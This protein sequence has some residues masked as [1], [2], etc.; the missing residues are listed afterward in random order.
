[1]KKMVEMKIKSELGLDAGSSYSFG[2]KNAK[3]I[4]KF[5]QG[6]RVI[7]EWSYVEDVDVYPKFL[8]YLKLERTQWT[9]TATING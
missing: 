8:K 1:M 3:D 6:I 7:D 5:A 9:V 2:V 4:E